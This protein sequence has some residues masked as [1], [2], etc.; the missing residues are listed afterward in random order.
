M[1]CRE[2]CSRLSPYIDNELERVQYD[3]VTEHLSSCEDC[4]SQLRELKLVD[5]HFSALCLPKPP[6][7][8]SL[9]TASPVQTDWV[10]MIGV[11]L[12]VAVSLLLVMSL[13]T[14]FMSESHPVVV[15]RD[16][17]QGHTTGHDIVGTLVVATGTVNVLSREQD[18]WRSC[19]PNGK[20][21]LPQGARIRTSADACCE[22]VMNSDSKLR[23]NSAAEVV[24]HQVDRVEFVSGKVWWHAANSPMRVEYPKERMAFLCPGNSEAQ[25]EIRDNR[26]A[27]ISDPEGP[28]QV[29]G[30]QFE[31]EVASGKSFTI[32]PNRGIV[33]ESPRQ[34]ITEKVWQLPLLAVSAT[35]QQELADLV[36]S[37]LAQ[38]GMTKATHMNEQQIR[39]LG[40]SGAIPLLAYVR[41]ERSRSQP[42]TRHH[43]IRIASATADHTAKDWLI[44]LT[45]DDDQQVK[46]FAEHALARLG[47]SQ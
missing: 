38:V 20:I 45:K 6:R 29:S 19:K 4:R 12:F 37:L 34:P 8:D 40:P 15:E 9:N 43:A 22:L 39:D 3:Q 26:L 5:A 23:L 13:G 14:R 46:R 10:G 17:D 2:C 1:K 30:Q 36:E 32:N 35:G 41:S 31:V 24:L 18:D 28:L 44:R 21:D 25:L 7:L 27:C 16:L 47:V 33:E 11:C 42:K